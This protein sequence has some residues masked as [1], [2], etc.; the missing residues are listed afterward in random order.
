M[1]ER[2]LFESK[3]LRVI[4]REDWEFVE[5]VKAKEAVAVVAVT[6]DGKIVLTEQERKP[7]QRR[8]LD[9]PAGLIG[10]DQENESPESSGRRELEEETG[11]TCDSLE[12]LATGPSSPGITS[13]L[14]HLYRARGVR[15]VGEGGGVEGEDIRVHAVPLAE[16]RDWLGRKQH[17]GLLVDLKVWSAL[18]FLS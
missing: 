5:R 7:M 6:A 4:D 10:D 1:G 14:V 16:L 18:H 9:L 15:H 13:E 2:V 12:H 8:V 11:Y 17:D 3:R